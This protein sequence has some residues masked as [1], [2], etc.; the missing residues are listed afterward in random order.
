MCKVPNACK[1]EQQQR[2]NML[3][4]GKYEQQQRYKMLVNG[5]YEQQPRYKMPVN[6]NMNSNNVTKGF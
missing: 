3:V 2:Y 4:N 1:H 5:K 6:G